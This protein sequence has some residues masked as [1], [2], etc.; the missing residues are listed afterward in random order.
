MYHLQFVP[1]GWHGLRAIYL[2][3][4]LHTATHICCAASQPQ[5]PTYA[6]LQWSLLFVKQFTLDI[7]SKTKEITVDRLMPAKLIGDP[8][9]V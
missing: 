4:D 2:T 8:G 3:P 6:P 1:T 5:T 9:T 7:N